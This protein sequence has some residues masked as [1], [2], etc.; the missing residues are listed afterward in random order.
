MSGYLKGRCVGAGRVTDAKRENSL[1]MRLT[2][3][4]TDS[5]PSRSRTAARAVR[6]VHPGVLIRVRR[7]RP[8]SLAEAT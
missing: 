2:Q 8:T 3:W 1:R 4:V 6:D 5:P 7:G